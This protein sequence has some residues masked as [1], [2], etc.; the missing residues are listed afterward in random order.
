MVNIRGGRRLTSIQHM[1]F[2]MQFVFARVDLE[3]FLEYVTI[4]L[5]VKAI[6][7]GLSFTLCKK[8]VSSIWKQGTKLDVYIIGQNKGE[9]KPRN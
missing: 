8:I 5:L 3:N 2:P 6:C 4:R 9:F 7:M 1:F